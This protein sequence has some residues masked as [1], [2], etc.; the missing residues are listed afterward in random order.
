VGQ[1]VIPKDEFIRF[2][3]HIGLELKRIKDD[4][5][6]WNKKN[7]PPLLRPVIFWHSGNEIP[8]F[9]VKTNLKTLGMTLSQYRKIVKKL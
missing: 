1:P 4:H 3:D 5:E 2:L 6:V 8:L 9:H 7:P